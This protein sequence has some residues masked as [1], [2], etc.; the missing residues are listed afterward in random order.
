MARQTDMEEQIAHLTRVVDDLSDELARQ[1][2][3]L[4]VAERRIAL[5]MA[6]AAEAE[7]EQ[8]GTIPLADQRP[9][10]W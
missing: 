7:S 4:E 2:K 10:H 8:G 1:G 3:A 5:L 9:P 6:R